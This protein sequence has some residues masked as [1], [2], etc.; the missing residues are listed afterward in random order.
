MLVVEPVLRDTRKVGH[1]MLQSNYAIDINKYMLEG[2]NKMIN[3]HINM[4]RSNRI[5][6]LRIDPDLIPLLGFSANKKNYWLRNPELPK[7]LSISNAITV[8]RSLEM[9]PRR[10]NM[11][12]TL[13]HKY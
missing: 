13:P 6:I 7:D 4:M 12:I 10:P 5:S 3:A 9:Y 2:N 1:G 8:N 11:G